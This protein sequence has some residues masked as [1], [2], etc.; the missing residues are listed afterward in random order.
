MHIVPNLGFVRSEPSGG[1]LKILTVGAFSIYDFQICAR[2]FLR[3]C[4]EEFNYI[5]D[6]TSTLVVVDVH[7]AKYRICPQRAV[8]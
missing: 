1:S 5:L 7:H 3:N 8:W 2:R 6:N 4:K